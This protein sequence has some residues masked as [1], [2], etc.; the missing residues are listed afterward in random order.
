MGNI[1]ART[2]ILFTLLVGFLSCASETSLT[3]DEDEIEVTSKHFK[4][5]FSDLDSANKDSIQNFIEGKYLGVLDDLQVDSMPTVEVH[6]YASKKALK[7]A[8]E[9][10]EPNLP[11]FAIGLAISAT[12][13]HMLSPNY[14]SLGVDYMLKNTVHEFAH[15]VSLHINPTI[16]NKPRWLWETVAIYEGNDRPNPDFFNYLTEGNPPS[17]DTLN[18]FD[19]TYIYEVGYFIGEFLIASKGKGVFKTLILNNGDIEK[20][21]GLNEKEFTTSWYKH[22]RKK[23]NYKSQKQ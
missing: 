16:A 18:R 17:L 11:D 13:I 5:F 7:K 23:Q 3:N 12:E 6:Y 15:C 20:T 9:E 21:L 14:P 8:V 1:L 4:F 2:T 19:N 10:V 22:L